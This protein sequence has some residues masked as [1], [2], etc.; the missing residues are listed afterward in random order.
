MHRCIDC[1]GEIQ[2]R[3]SPC[4]PCAARMADCCT[5]CA[6]RAASRPY[7]SYK[8]EHFGDDLWAVIGVNS[9]TNETGADMFNIV[10]A[11]TSHPMLAATEAE[12][13]DIIQRMQLALNLTRDELDAVLAATAKVEPLLARKMRKSLGRER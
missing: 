3:N 8:V 12:T 5:A 13:T 7:S 6:E 4:T 9:R 1:G 10:R 11:P 2:V